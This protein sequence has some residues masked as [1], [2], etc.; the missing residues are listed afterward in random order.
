[1]LPPL[2]ILLTM[3][4]GSSTPRGRCPTRQRSDNAWDEQRAQGRGSSSV[5]C[6]GVLRAHRL[7]KPHRTEVGV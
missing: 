7:C 2:M 5:R 3:W 6:R 1:V 4:S